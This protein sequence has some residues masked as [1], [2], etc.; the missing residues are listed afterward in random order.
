M[1]YSKLKIVQI[2]SHLNGLE[3]LIVRKPEQL[4]E[5]KTAVKNVDASLAL[6]KISHEKTMKGKIL[7]SPSVLNALFKK[8]FSEKNWHELRTDYFVN[9]DLD[10]TREIINIKD[11]EKQKKIITDNGF[12]AYRSYNQVDFV[13][14]RIA[15]EIQFGKYFS[16][17]YDLHVKHTFF[18]Q[19]G[20]IDVGIEIIP[21]HNLMS[22]MSTG[23]AW[24]E[25]ELTNIVREGR[26]NP[27]IPLVL[28]GI[29]PD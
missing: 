5:L 1:G 19:R 16:V 29:E 8:Q 7:Y 15:I 20:E 24:Y 14:D 11:K 4:E 13:K 9:E 25:N 22:K 12:T 10:T 6:C 26:S 18:Y 2:Y 21:T 3:F 17:Q 28:I 27:S 23:V